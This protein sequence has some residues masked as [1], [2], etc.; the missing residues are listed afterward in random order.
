MPERPGDFRLVIRA[1]PGDERPLAVRLRHVLK[2]LL[3]G[4]GF[5]CVSIEE[6]PGG[7]TPTPADPV[8]A[9]GENRH[10]PR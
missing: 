10:A 2:G 8:Q 6:L 4:Q 1:V 5:R 9:S 3:R 7:T